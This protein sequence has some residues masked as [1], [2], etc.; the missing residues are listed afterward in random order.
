MGSSKSPVEFRHA[1]LANGLEIVAE[2]SPDSYSAA[3]AY[4]V[5]T[6]ARDESPE[7]AGVSHFLEHMVF[8]GTEKRTSV[9]VNRELDE[10]S[11]SSNAYTSEEQTVYYATTLPDDQQ[12]MVE[13]L[14]DIMRPSLRQDDF[15]TEKKVILEEIAKY[16]D[17]PPYNAFEKCVS[18]FWGNHPLANSIL[19]TVDSVGA[20]TRDQMMAYFKQRY[21]PGNMV[22]AAA[23]NVDFDALVKAAEDLCCKWEPQEAP[24]ETPPFQL[25]E[26]TRV[27]HKPIAAQQYVIQSAMAPDARD[28][29]RYAARLLAT[30]VGDDSGS[31]MFWELIDTGEAEYAA[32]GCMEFQ[33]AGLF[34]TSLSC[35]PNQTGDNLKK[36]AELLA[37]VHENGVTEEEL[38]QAKNK[39]CAHLVLQ[40]ERPSNRMFSVGGGW[41][42]RRQYFTVRD[43]V[44]KYRRVT[45]EDIARVLAKYPLNR[46][47]TFGIGPLEQLPT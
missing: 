39:I 27:E 8:K 13:L 24:R 7:V 16:E 35:M 2:T 10:L 34:L 29:D 9:E 33:G 28:D 12:P 44:Q 43:V 4:M 19:G 15:D 32:L 45:T 25:Q 17:A 37:E 46:N 47:A 41:V 3:Y 36:L 21:S 14:T 26:V 30:I 38:E 23:G 40:A 6:G 18:A 11:S 20:L 5:K 22:L 42:Q 31:R 1:K